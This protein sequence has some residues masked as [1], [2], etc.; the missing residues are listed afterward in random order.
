M[1]SINCIWPFA[2]VFALFKP[3]FTQAARHTGANKFCWST[4]FLM[5]ERSNITV[6]DNLRWQVIDNNNCSVAHTR[7]M[8]NIVHL[9]HF[10][11]STDSTAA[12]NPD[13]L[14]VVCV[15]MRLQIWTLTHRCHWLRSM[16][17]E[18]TNTVIKS[19]AF[20]EDEVENYS[21]SVK[22]L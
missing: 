5:R 12:T 4:P 21:G 16:I 1:Q 8:P 3:R 6:T 10:C 15:L 11:C 2:A 20:H 7:N 17:R 18:K 9:Q 19:H 14:F 13:I 22:P